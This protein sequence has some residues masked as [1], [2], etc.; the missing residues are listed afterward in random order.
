ME[1][2]IDQVERESILDKNQFGFRKFHS[3]WNP[4]LLTVNYI[5]KE[6]KAKKHV[7]LVS[8]D[9]A[10][11]FDTCRTDGTLQNKISYFCNNQ[12]FVNWID[13]CY[14]NRGQYTI[15]SG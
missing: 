14:Q 5:Q 6:I 13:S 11:A 3:T 9:L 4:L 2:V 7:V 10:K 12:S 1:Q 8:C 15:E